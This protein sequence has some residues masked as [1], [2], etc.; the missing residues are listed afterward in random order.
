MLIKEQAE[1][2][3]GPSDTASLAPAVCRKT[4][5]VYVVKGTALGSVIPRRR[6]SPEA[7]ESRVEERGEIK[8]E[9]HQVTFKLIRH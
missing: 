8:I 9:A 5:Q 2:V 4:Q 6:L 1:L 3:S 7:S